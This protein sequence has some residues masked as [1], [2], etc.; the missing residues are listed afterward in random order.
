MQV[1]DHTVKHPAPWIV[2]ILLSLS[3]ALLI[4]SS[5]LFGSVLYVSH[6]PRQ[7]SEI[8]GQ[9][10]FTSSVIAL[11]TLQRR[12][13]TRRDVQVEDACCGNGSCVHLRNRLYR[14]ELEFY[15][16]K[17]QAGIALSK[18]LCKE[19]GKD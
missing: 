6:L 13:R 1:S 4:I 15:M 8:E 12:T 2:Y 19:K 11:D 10:V 5:V 7:A 9:D 16:F 3:I 14:F 17:R 18:C